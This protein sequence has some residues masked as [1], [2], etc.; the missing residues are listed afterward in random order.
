MRARDGP[1]PATR[2]LPR[3]AWPHP[4]GQATWLVLSPVAED[5]QLRD[6]AGLAPD[7]ADQLVA[8]VTLGRPRPRDKRVRASC[9]RHEGLRERWGCGEML[10]EVG[11]K[12]RRRRE[13]AERAREASLELERLAGR[14][15]H[16]AVIL[17]SA[18]L[19][20][21]RPEGTGRP[22]R[23]RPIAKGQTVGHSRVHTRQDAGHRPRVQ[24]VAKQQQAAALCPGHDPRADSL[25]Q[26]VE[27]WPVLRELAGED[28]GE[29]PCEV[30]ASTVSRKRSLA[31]RIES[32]ELGPGLALELEV[33]GIDEAE[34]LAGADRDA[35]AAYP[36]GSRRIW[37]RG[38]WRSARDR[39][40]RVEVDAAL[41]HPSEALQRRAHG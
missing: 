39:Q 33:L 23:R 35:G 1:Y 20:A 41:D 28:L 31:E 17:V 32:D 22:R 16:A 4:T 12:E 15:R 7:F 30:Q 19:S 36:L 29:A 10:M 26:R 9:A 38:A 6:S 21:R 18:P 3:R 34:D 14:I 25:A 37:H 24:R 13:T 11:G 5:R 40:E 27:Q 8:P 2:S